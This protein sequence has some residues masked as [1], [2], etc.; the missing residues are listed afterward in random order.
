MFTAVL[1]PKPVIIIQVLQ[2]IITRV[3]MQLTDVIVMM[4]ESMLEPILT[5]LLPSLSTLVLIVRATSRAGSPSSN[6]TN[7]L[8]KTSVVLAFKTAFAWEFCVG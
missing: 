7:T 8:K 5:I 2:L 6:G 4:L 3:G 1:T